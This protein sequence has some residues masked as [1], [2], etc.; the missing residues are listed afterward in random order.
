M[1]LESVRRAYRRYAPVYDLVFGPVMNMG[2]MRTVRA[3]NQMAPPRIL[4]VGVGTG[5][6]LPHYRRD[7]DI[8]GID[9]SAD[10]L[11]VARE[12]VRQKGLSNVRG[13]HEM[14]AE[15]LEFDDGEFDVVVAM[16][17]MSVVPH[18]ELCLSEMRRVCKPGGVIVIC[19]H[20]YAE[21]DAGRP[22]VQLLSPMARWLGWRPDFRL[23]AILSDS[24][25]EV[26]SNQS[27]PPLGLFNVLQCRNGL[28]A[29]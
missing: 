17:V 2:R 12:R 21:D 15:K 6:S 25:L 13:L 1:D 26:M 8:V 10:M 7:I 23:D 28:A 18:P 20:F 27:V 3:V 16:Y 19:N 5:L 11:A 4:E 24:D 9:V 14:D 22:L 29:A